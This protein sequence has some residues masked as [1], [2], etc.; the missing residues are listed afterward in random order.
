MPV[1]GTSLHWEVAPAAWR[2]SDDTLHVAAAADT[3]LFAP[4]LGGKRRTDAARA[5]TPHPPWGD[6]Q[7]S[8]RLKVGFRTPWDAGALLLWSDE[9][10][11]AK[12]NF[13]YSPAE[14]P[15]I[16]S[17][18]TRGLSDDAVGRPVATGHLWLRI[19]RLGGAYAFY[20]SDDGASW[21]LVR[22]FALDGPHPA[23]PGIVVQSPAGAGC[24]VEFDAISLVRTPRT[25]H[26][27]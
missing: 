6:W 4:P 25:D 11:W 2:Q 7:F 5:L 13:E 3:D 14:H 27:G 16:Y 26:R 23:R 8:A 20:A 10:H 17:V 22:Q 1:T 12:V 19:A 24:E 9:R 18:V 21:S 15:A